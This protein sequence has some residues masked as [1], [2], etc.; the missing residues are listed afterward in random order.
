M[1]TPHKPCAIEW[2]NIDAKRA[3]FTSIIPMIM[4]HCL[5]HMMKSSN[6]LALYS[7]VVNFIPWKSLKLLILKHWDLILT[8]NIMSC[9]TYWNYFEPVL[10]L[11]L[12]ISIFNHPLCTYCL[13]C[14]IYR[15]S[16]LPASFTPLTWPDD[17]LCVWTKYCLIIWV[18]YYFPWVRFTL[19]L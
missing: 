10:I 5:H 17:V 16:L 2:S 18:F 12:S 4:T 7:K 13:N 6:F 11:L 3:A 9:M 19:E 8:L 14:Y 15:T 1:V